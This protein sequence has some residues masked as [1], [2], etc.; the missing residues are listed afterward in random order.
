MNA[1]RAAS[2]CGNVSDGGVTALPW[3]IWPGSPGRNIWFTVAKNRSTLPL[4]RG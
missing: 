1:W 3:T 4:P 2:S